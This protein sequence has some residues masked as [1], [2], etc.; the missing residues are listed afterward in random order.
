MRRLLSQTFFVLFAL[1][2]A[3]WAVIVTIKPGPPG[4]II[5]ASGGADGHYQDL[6]LAYKKQLEHYGV[7][8]ELRPD[9]EGIDTL[10]GLFPQFKPEFTSYNERSEGV[11]AG[12]IKGG[13]SGSL[14]G[15]LA[16]AREQVWHERQVENLRSIGRLFYE[17]LWAFYKSAQPLRSLKGLKGKTLYVGTKIGGARR[18]VLQLLKANGVTA[19]NTKYV[20]EDIGSDAAPLLAGSA[21]AAFLMLPPES[22]KVQAL[23]RNA[24]IQLMNFAAEADAYTARFPALTKLVLR[25]GAI[26]FDPET[27]G[28][29]TTLLA[30][31]GGACGADGPGP[32]AD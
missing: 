30:T 28:S 21:D 16:S 3:A 32:G 12:F 24:Q 18:V 23:L 22:A 26:E 1:L 27:P 5:I 19:E 15:R 7:E 8:A 9:V 13:F 31:L 6:A 20:D 29:D 11:Q 2:L 17:P 10:K 14:R 25:Q 4:K